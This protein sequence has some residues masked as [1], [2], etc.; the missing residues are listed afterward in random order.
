M[1]SD[2]AKMEMAGDIM[3]CTMALQKPTGDVMEI[4]SIFQ[5]VN[6]RRHVDTEKHTRQRIF[7][8]LYYQDAKSSRTSVNFPLRV[9]IH[10]CQSLKVIK[11]NCLLFALATV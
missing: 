2:T 4:M 5:S 8:L 1:E 10:I 7:K 11:N 3:I 9:C 6:N